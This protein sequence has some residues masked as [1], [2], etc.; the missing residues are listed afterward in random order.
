ML[1]N[2]LVLENAADR[3]GGDNVWYSGRR[4]NE[5]VCIRQSENFRQGPTLLDSSPPIFTFRNTTPLAVL[6]RRDQLSEPHP[7]LA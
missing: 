7:R 3:A 2:L 4:D 5:P 6:R 1:S